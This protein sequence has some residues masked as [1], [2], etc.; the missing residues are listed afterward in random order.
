MKDVAR[1]AGV[2][3]KT[4][5]RVVNNE[6]GVAEA[7][8]ERVQATLA[9]MSFRR[10]DIAS[11]LRH[12]LTT[13]SIGLVTEDLA[14]PFYAMLARAVGEIAR[15]H[16]F[17][18]LSGSSDESEEREREILTAFLGRRVDGLIVVP[19]GGSQALLESERAA[20]VQLVF[21]DRPGI[22]VSADTVLIDNAAGVLT[23]VR[24][25]V[26]YGHRRIGYLGDDPGI[27]TAAERMRGF[28]QAVVTFG[29]DSHPGLVRPG[30]HDSTAAEEQALSMLD[31]RNPPTALFAGNNLITAGV[32][33]AMRRRG[34]APVALVGFDDFDLADLVDPPVTVIAQDAEAMGRRAAE[35]MFARLAGDAGPPVTEV[36]P[37]R[38]IVRG[39]GEVLP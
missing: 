23:G 5:S 37:T 24:H 10:N 33:R 31:D 16:G 17:L 9:R 12:K 25:L 20:G 11:S 13:S 14:N 3:L 6:P 35:R 39:S 29:L 38:L 36:L 18:V 26:Q 34:G 1:S 27:Y 15:G 19:T 22:G 7:T 21:V 30:L 4:V 28:R 8:A 32:L 2:S